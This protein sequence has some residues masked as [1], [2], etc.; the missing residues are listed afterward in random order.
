[1]K[2]FMHCH[3]TFELNVCM[4]FLKFMRVEM[5]KEDGLGFYLVIFLDLSCS[6][7]LCVNLLCC[8]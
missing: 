1:M 4:W 2:N 6:V 8:L 7:V 5:G 3:V